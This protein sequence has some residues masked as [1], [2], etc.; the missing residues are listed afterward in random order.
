MASVYDK[1]KTMLKSQ[2]LKIDIGQL[3][4]FRSLL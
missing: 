3:F 1:Y 4:N 2:P